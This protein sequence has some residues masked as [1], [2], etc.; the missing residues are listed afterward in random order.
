MGGCRSLGIACSKW[1]MIQTLTRSQRAQTRRERFRT[2]FFQEILQLSRRDRKNIFFFKLQEEKE[3]LI[4]KFRLKKNR[5][6][7]SLER[8]M[9]QNETW[10]TG[11]KGDRG[12]RGNKEGR[13]DKENAIF[14]FLFFTSYLNGS[15]NCNLRNVAQETHLFGATS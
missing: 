13:R 11:G 7:I 1:S 10:K 2:S 9:G 3:K 8:N 12:Y 6:I 14:M 15:V 5:K 4:L